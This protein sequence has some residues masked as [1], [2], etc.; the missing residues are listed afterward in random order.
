MIP[1]G[2]ACVEAEIIVRL[3]RDVA[4]AA[5]EWSIERAISCVAEVRLGVELAGS[6]VPDLNALGPMAVASDFGNNAGVVLGP[7]I[8]EWEARGWEDLACRTWIDGALVA[9]GRPSG[10]PGGVFEGVRHALAT[11]SARGRSL[12]AGDLIATGAVTGVHDVVP[13][14]VARVEFGDLHRFDLRLVAG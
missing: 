14:Q 9:S 13:G 8:P 12:L 7:A 3:G 4:P 5:G 2:T 1:G 11:C 6:P 10:L